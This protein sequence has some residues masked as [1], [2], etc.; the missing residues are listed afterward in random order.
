MNIFLLIDTI[1]IVLILNQPK[2][3]HCAIVRMETIENMKIDKY[4]IEIHY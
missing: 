2:N 3:V 1:F 4:V